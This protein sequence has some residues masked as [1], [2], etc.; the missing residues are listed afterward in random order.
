MPFISTS[1]S[2]VVAAVPKSLPVARDAEQ[3][4]RVRLE[5][6]PDRVWARQMQKHIWTPAAV[7]VHDEELRRNDNR[8]RPVAAAGSNQMAEALG[9]DE[10]PR[11]AL[12]QRGVPWV[13]QHPT[14]MWDSVLAAK[15]GMRN[16]RGTG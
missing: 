7:A 14:I 15:H 13:N 2:G 16:R 4:E 6:R 10:P 8:Q 3:H 1:A 9:A 5:R 12:V 11:L